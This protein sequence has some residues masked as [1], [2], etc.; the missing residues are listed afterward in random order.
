MRLLNIKT[1]K[2]EYF[3]GDPPPYAILS[4]TWGQGEVT[5][6]D[7]EL[8]GLDQKPGWIKIVGF[9]KA[10]TRKFGD[11]IEYAWVDTCCI[12]KTS[13]AELSEAI[14]AMFLWYKLAECCFAFLEDVNHDGSG[15]LGQD[16]EG[17]RW[18]DRGWTLQELLAPRHMEFFDRNWCYIGNK[19]NLADRISRR[20]SIDVK[21]LLTGSFTT[22]SVA[23]RMSWAAG[24]E[25]TRPEDLAYCLL[26]IFDINMPMLYGEGEKAF[27][28]LQEE[29]IK[30]YDDQ[31]IFAWDSSDIPK[32][33]ATVGVFA[34]HPSQFKNSSEIEPHPSSG[35][36]LAI[37][38]KG[39]QL[40]I[41]LIEQ[42][43][44]PGELLGLLSCISKGDMA[45]AIGIVLTQSSINRKQYSRTR[46]MPVRFGTRH[47]HFKQQRVYL[48]K[49]NSSTGREEW[50]TTCWLSYVPTSSLKPVTT[51]PPTFWHHSASTETMT[52]T[53]PYA[54]CASSMHVL[55]VAAFS[56]EQTASY[57]ALLLELKPQKR[58]IKT[59][60]VSLEAKP[61][62]IDL[63]KITK[64]FA[65]EE[66]TVDKALDVKGG[67]VITNSSVVLTRGAW[68]YVIQ[69]T[70]VE[71]LN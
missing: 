44:Q 70:F 61:T 34:T 32:S 16:F 33:I 13:S 49:K 55:A 7:L 62:D 18:F 4:H 66:D 46:S 69:V 48:T 53:M 56:I 58:S 45:S 51:Y 5:L 42:Q 26:G 57:C 20:T 17:C 3:L 14:N 63:G 25:T 41:A 54:A 24:R 50:A 1:Q 2:L 27:I 22:A 11:T 29:I 9:L 65:R 31:S 52:M 37:T 28:R 38:N 47:S 71:A 23:K 67:S 64:Q 12:D 19:H 60:L 59:W 35:E 15:P 68:M 39:I 10:L 21:S 43:S 40:D 8:D 6:Q 36:P 30:E